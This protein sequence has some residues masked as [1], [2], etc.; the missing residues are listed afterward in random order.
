MEIDALVKDLNTIAEMEITVFHPTDTA[1]ARLRGLIAELVE[2]EEP[3][4][5]KAVLTQIRT[6]LIGIGQ[7]GLH[8]PE[9]ISGDDAINAR[10]QMDEL[11]DIAFRA[12]NDLLSKL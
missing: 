4:Q 3:A 10:N 1:S 7:R 9:G 5:Q 11:A 2:A 6:Q 12:I 8:I